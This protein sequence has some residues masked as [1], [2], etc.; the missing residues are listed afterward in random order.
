MRPPGWTFLGAQLAIAAGLATLSIAERHRH[1]L[2]EAEIRTA[3]VAARA[4][5]EFPED[6]AGSSPG[7]PAA[8]PEEPVDVGEDD[9]TEADPLDSVEWDEPGTL[10]LDRQRVYAD[11]LF[12][13]LLK[14]ERDGSDL[15]W[16]LED[17]DPGVALEALLRYWPQIA[18]AGMRQE[19]LENVGWNEGSANVLALVDLGM[20]DAD[21]NVRAAALNALFDHFYVEL[22]DDPAA[23][24]AW[25][26]RTRGSTDEE[27]LRL[28]ARDLVRR[29]EELGPGGGAAVYARLQE[30]SDESPQALQ[31]AGLAPLLEKWL[32]SGPE[33]AELAVDLLNYAETDPE[34]SR[35]HVLPLLSNPATRATALRALGSTDTDWAL[36]EAKTWLGTDD[37]LTASAAAGAVARL[38][39][40]REAIPLLIAALRK[41]ESPDAR[42][43]IIWGGLYGL[44]Q[45]PGS[46]NHTV[47][48]WEDWWRHNSAYYESA[49]GAR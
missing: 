28:G 32:A 27:L 24:R 38:A 8:E 25:R 2:T 34:W 1:V 39:P 6:P 16:G 30:A 22:P 26:D 21:A 33:G 37:Y 36:A 19:L 49:E 42:S 11:L 10:S 15:A 5:G 12:Q 3:E 48:W 9:D 41:A 31:E 29:L 7:E 47:E 17:C 40:P 20:G 13:S 45:I 14:D 4:S 44:T 18:D 35:L 46:R 23:W 43:A